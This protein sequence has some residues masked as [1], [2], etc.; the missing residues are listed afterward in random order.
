MDISALRKLAIT[1][2]PLVEIAD[3]LEKIQAS[4][5]HLSSIQGR[6]V[7]ANKEL[8]DARDA[9]NKLL[10]SAKEEADKIALSAKVI[11]KD[12]IDAAKVKSQ[13]L[14]DTANKDIKNQAAKWSD[15][16]RVLAENKVSLIKDVSAIE[17]KKAASSKE[18]EEIESRLSKAKAEISRMLG[19]S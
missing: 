7:A 18:L 10:G 15:D 19:Q 3:V 8:A 14:I 4:E 16:M 13:Q 12:E 1:L 11:A 2:K 5:D 6:I 17:A 9:A